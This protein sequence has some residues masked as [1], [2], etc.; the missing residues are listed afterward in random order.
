M[1]IFPL[2][3]F[4]YIF[5]D[6]SYACDEGIL[7]YGGDLNP[8][9]IIKAYMNGIFPW[10]AKDD[11][12]LW[13]SPNPR[14][15]LSLDEFK[16]SKSLFKTLQ[17]KHLTVKFNQQFR[18]VITLCSKVPRVGQQGTWILPEM[19]E[20]Y[21]TLHE[22]GFAHSFETYEGDVLVGGGYGVAMGNVFSGESMFSLKSNASK[23]ALYHLVEHLKKQDFTCI[24]C[25][26]PTP[27]L[28]SLG[29]RE[30]TREDFLELIKSALEKPRE[31]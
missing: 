28:K 14:M 25:Q 10:Y 1:N 29:A 30:I 2:D 8:N 15:I 9:R 13:W 22:M 27:H 6:P 5:P 20:A 19:I 24:D 11:P 7:A 18:N 31:F 17:K 12:I 21:C 4:S 26:V 16:C 23:V 3:K